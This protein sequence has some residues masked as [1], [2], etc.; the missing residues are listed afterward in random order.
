MKTELHT[1]TSTSCLIRA[2]ATIGP[3]WPQSGPAWIMI[4]AVMAAMGMFHRGCQCGGDGAGAIADT[5]TRGAH[6]LER[7]ASKKNLPTFS[8]A[9]THTGVDIMFGRLFLRSSSRKRVVNHNQYLSREFVRAHGLGIYRFRVPR[10]EP[11]S[12]QP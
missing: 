12:T 3:P 9:L 5:V 10:L 4:V 6:Q 1:C 11:G 8:P 7:S 2:R